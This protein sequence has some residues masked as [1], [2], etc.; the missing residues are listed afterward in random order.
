MSTRCARPPLRY[1]PPGDTPSA[2]RLGWQLWALRPGLDGGAPTVHDDSPDQTHRIGVASG[3]G[4]GEFAACAARTDVL[5]EPTGGPFSRGHRGPFFS[6]HF[7]RGRA[8]KRTVPEQGASF[9]PAGLSRLR[10][11]PPQEATR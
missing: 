8:A 2:P 7:H 9:W 4:A 11:P 10:Q 1:G 5:M 6:C 3:G